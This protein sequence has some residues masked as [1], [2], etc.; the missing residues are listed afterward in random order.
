MKNL[1]LGYKSREKG[2]KGQVLYIGNDGPRAREI[3]NSPDEDTFVKT[4]IFTLPFPSKTRHFNT[5]EEVA[6]SEKAKEEM[7]EKAKE[8]H[9]T[10]A[11][12]KEE[13]E[14]KPSPEEAESSA[15]PEEAQAAGKKKVSKK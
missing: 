12:L 14:S 8:V 2:A 10:R 6:K 3:L 11:A 7:A 13:A 1:V 5:P 15:P 4:A 9:E